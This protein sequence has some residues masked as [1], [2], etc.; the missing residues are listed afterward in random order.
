MAV[1]DNS[2]LLSL[3]LVVVVVTVDDTVDIAG[4]TT[5]PFIMRIDIKDNDQL[6][7]LTWYGSLNLLFNIRLTQHWNIPW[8]LDDPGTDEAS[9]LGVRRTTFLTRPLESTLMEIFTTST[10][11]LLVEGVM[12]EEPWSLR[13]IF[14][15]TLVVVL[16]CSIFI[17]SNM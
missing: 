1:E 17:K 2:I 3:L 9:V 11:E 14:R 5:L 10:A 15:L 7:S 4:V 16:V 8:P 6:I 13:F 12:S